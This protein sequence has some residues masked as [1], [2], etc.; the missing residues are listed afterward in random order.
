LC[1]SG[2]GLPIGRGAGHHAPSIRLRDLD[3]FIALSLES[4]WLAFP[5]TILLWV[6]EFG[7]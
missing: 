6:N 5:S 4:H 7:A 2:E 1:N 3:S